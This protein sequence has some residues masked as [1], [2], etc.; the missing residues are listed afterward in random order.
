V[1][2]PNLWSGHSVAPRQRAY[3]LCHGQFTKERTTANRRNEAESKPRSPVGECD[4][5][6]KGRLD[7]DLEKALVK[8]IQS[9]GNGGLVPPLPGHRKPALLKQPRTKCDSLKGGDQAL[10]AEQ[11]TIH[12]IY[13]ALRRAPSPGPARGLAVDA[14]FKALAGELTL[15]EG[16]VAARR[17]TAMFNA[18]TRLSF[19]DKNLQ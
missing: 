4:V 12:A 19:N 13:D 11:N 7:P 16:P 6:R 5:G 18:H 15:S 2:H 3:G 1:S 8:A 10:Q 14:A 17:M 9:F